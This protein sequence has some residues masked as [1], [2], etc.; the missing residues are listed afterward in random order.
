MKIIRFLIPIAVLVLISSTTFVHGDYQ[1]TV[2]Q[3]FTY[4]V[5]RSFWRVKL[6]DDSGSSA[7]Y[8]IGLSNMDEGTSFDILVTDVIPDTSVDY[9]ITVESHTYPSSNDFMTFAIM[10]FDL[11][12]FNVLS[13][14][15]VGSWNQAFVD[16]GPGLFGEFF[17]NTKVSNLN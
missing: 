9:N 7:K 11:F 6:G 5:N 4:T 17:F 14:A 10:L 12:E 8:N 1:V 2:G 3:T 13:T 16:T 15:F